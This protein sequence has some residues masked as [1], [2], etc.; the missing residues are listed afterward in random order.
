[1]FDQIKETMDYQP[2]QRVQILCET[3][4]L[5]PPPPTKVQERLAGRTAVVARL[6][7]KDAGA[8]IKLDGAPD[9]LLGK[10][11]LVFPRECRILN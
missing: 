5:A 8:W 6:R 3:Q 2:G 9:P 1:M 10:E 7:R 4:C 11:V